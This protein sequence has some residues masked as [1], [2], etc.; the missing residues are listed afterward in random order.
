MYCVIV[1]YTW[2]PLAQDTIQTAI[3]LFY[4][5]RLVVG[6]VGQL[7]VFPSCLGKHKLDYDRAH[8]MALDWFP[9]NEWLPHN[10]ISGIQ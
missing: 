6:G 7:I 2:L 1:D 9:Q 5:Q 10:A 8:D 3:E 4:C